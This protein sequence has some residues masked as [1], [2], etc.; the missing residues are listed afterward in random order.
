[1]NVTKVEKRDVFEYLPV[2]NNDG[3]LH[4]TLA[5]GV[6]G[7]REGGKLLPW[8]GCQDYGPGNRIHRHHTYR[9]K[10]IDRPCDWQQE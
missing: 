4:P 9:Y 6:K 10:H 1:M 3:Q 8:S 5:E 7:M 2:V